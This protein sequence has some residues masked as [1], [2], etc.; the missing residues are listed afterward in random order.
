MTRYSDHMDAFWASR[1]KEQYQARAEEEFQVAV[2]VRVRS[3]GLPEEHRSNIIDRIAREV[4]LAFKGNGRID[5]VHIGE[6]YPSEVW[7]LTAEV[8]EEEV[9]RVHPEQEVSGVQ[10][11]GSSGRGA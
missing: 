1:D 6:D 4:H 11:N 9:Q 2:L 10:G 3:T 5:E 8:V 7:V